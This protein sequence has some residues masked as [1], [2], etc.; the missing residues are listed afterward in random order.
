V[1]LNNFISLKKE[2]A[3]KRF[4]LAALFLLSTSLFAQTTIDFETVGNNWGWTLFSAGTGGSFGIVAN[5]S[6]GGLNTSDSCAMLVVGADGDPWAGVFSTD[7]PDMTINANN[8]IVKILVYKNV[9]SRFNLKL[10]P[11]NVDHFDSNT[12][13]NQWEELIFDYSADIGTNS[14]TLTLIPDMEEGGR[15]HASVNYIDYIQFTG[16]VPVELTSFTGSYIGQTVNLN[17]ATATETNNYGFEIQRS[18]EGGSFAT[19]AFVQGKG[20]T[21]E[22]Q[23]YNFI[24]K[25]ITSRTNYSYRLK[26]IDFDGHFDF[27]NVVNLGASLP[28]SMV[29]DQ[30]YPNPFNPSTTISF[31]IPSKSNVSLDVYNL[32]GQ[33]VMTLVSGNLEEGTYKYN[34][35][36]SNLSSGIYV[37]SLAV[38]NESG[39]SKIISKKM[40]LLK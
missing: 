35:D 29:L 36:A 13:V 11:P 26:Q 25:N 20:T 2:C 15:T 14:A 1:F 21:T 31:A 7:F 38:T 30:N 39:S 33:K 6:V 28:T 40:T 9:T 37:Y 18:S 16:I 19:V 32:V 34:I 24:D 10:E 3:M 5:P 8:C 22:T 23:N 4:L 12:V 27:S 17:W